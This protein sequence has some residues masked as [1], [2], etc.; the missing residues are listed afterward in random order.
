[1]VGGNAVARLDAGGEGARRIKAVKKFEQL[2]YALAYEGLNKRT[3]DP[4]RSAQSLDIL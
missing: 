2:L 1:M 4:R 3:G